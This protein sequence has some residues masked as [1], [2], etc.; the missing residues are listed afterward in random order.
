MREAAQFSRH[1]RHR[2][3][4][5]SPGTKAQS[6][7]LFE[8]LRLQLEHVSTVRIVIAADGNPPLQAMEWRKGGLEPMR[9]LMSKLIFQFSIRQNTPKF[10]T[11]PVTSVE[12]VCDQVA[13]KTQ[14]ELVVFAG[15][16]ARP[17]AV[18]G[19]DD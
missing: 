11:S 4:S 3:V 13:W 7:P 6:A 14:A 17:G 15:D 1:H 18:V 2:I 10:K 9:R 12:N 16:V 19:H 5:N 8:A